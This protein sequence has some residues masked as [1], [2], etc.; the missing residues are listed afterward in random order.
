MRDLS[1]WS[2]V[3]GFLLVALLA[4]GG[5]SAATGETESLA[6]DLGVEVSFSPHPTMAEAFVCQV[7]ITDLRSGELLSAPRI[8]SRRGEEGVV[9]F[10]LANGEHLNL[11]VGLDA[12]GK[13]A[14]Y[15]SQILRGE[16]VLSRQSVT[17]SL[18][19][20]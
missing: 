5:S 4:W 18:D 10:G 1:K 7:E 3:A 2:L 8:T 9:R 20:V 14:T 19:S 6:R 12:S 11:T 16:T 15:V 13:V 17:F